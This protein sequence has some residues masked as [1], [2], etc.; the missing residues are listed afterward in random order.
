MTVSKE[1]LCKFNQ[2]CDYWYDLMVRTYKEAAKPLVVTADNYDWLMNNY[3]DRTRIETI[4]N[5]AFY[6]V[7]IRQ[8]IIQ[9]IRNIHHRKHILFSLIE[10]KV[11]YGE[12][13][14]EALKPHTKLIKQTLINI[15]QQDMM[16]KQ[17]DAYR[18]TR[19]LFQ[20]LG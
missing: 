16:T 14:F 10:Y 7:W 9:N 8:P 19:E 18:G 6:L 13:D 17:R 12:Q 20:S 2:Q 5:Q 15:L 1:T 3:I 4:E 11:S